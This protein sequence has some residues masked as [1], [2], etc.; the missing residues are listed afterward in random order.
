MTLDECYNEK[1]D[2]TTGDT[3]VLL[4]DVIQTDGCYL[5]VPCPYLVLSCD[6]LYLLRIT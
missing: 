4:L 5:D 1:T 3:C 2:P 6:A